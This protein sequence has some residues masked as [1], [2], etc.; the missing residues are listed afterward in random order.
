MLTFAAPALL[1]ALPLAAA[2]VVF[3]LFFRVRTRAVPFPTLMFLQRIEPR[4]QSRRRLREFLLLALRTLLILLVI[5]ALARPQLPALAGGGSTALVVVLDNSASLGRNGADGRSLAQLA[6]ECS[7]ALG[8]ALAEADRVG[9]VLTVEDP[10][11]A[12]GSGALGSRALFSAALDQVRPT[13]AEGDAAGALRRAFTVLAAS[14]APNRELRILSD[15]QS[16]EWGQAAATL[17]PPPGCRIT[18]HPLRAQGAP[19][20]VSIRRV[21]PPSSRAVVGRPARST[22][23]LANAS[24]TAATVRLL[25]N[26]GRG[27]I[28]TT[29]VSV[30]ASSELAVPA[31]LTPPTPGQHHALITLEGEVFAPAARAGL[32][33][34][35][36]AA[37]PVLLVTAQTPGQTDP[38]GLLALALAP[39]GRGAVSGLAPRLV[40][41]AQ[42]ADGLAAKPALVVTTWTSLGA[43][44]EPA[45]RAWV[46]AGGTLLVLPAVS[47]AVGSTAPAPPAWIGA[48]PGV[49]EALTP[50]AAGMVLDPDGACW[51]DLRDGTGRIALGDLRI[52]R[53]QVL[54]P[55]DGATAALGTSDGRALLVEHPVGNGRVVSLGV[56]FHPGWSNLPLKG[57]SLALV[58]GLALRHAGGANILRL[59]AGQSLPPAPGD[60]T[61]IRI[62]ALNGGPFAWQGPREAAPPFA[63]AGVALVE[64]SGQPALP[65]VVCAAGSEADPAVADGGLLAHLTHRRVPLDD[66]AQVVADWKAVRRGSDLF[67]WLVLAALV[68]WA[69]ESWLG[70]NSAVKVRTHD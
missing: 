4:L 40:P 13:E 47:A 52:A 10:A 46:A 66:A 63:H 55:V 35:A 28:T 44:P 50:S 69:V 7:A 36:G 65:V 1:W 6:G 59:S 9:L 22:V 62:S 48:V 24:N 54:N 67:L 33:V 17:V 68:V 30:P 26:A 21:D 19:G 27:A 16:G 8:K 14:D 38:F 34:A 42:L 2:P 41:A 56:A 18:V 51:G 53:C 11:V 15:L 23:V 64:F 61:P 25:V 37:V 29:A 31:L 5:L 12:T 45:L 57:W 43:S 20:A 3:H 39:D 60:R 58:Q 70:S 49:V 32:V